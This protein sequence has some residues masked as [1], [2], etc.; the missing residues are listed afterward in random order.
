M[1]YNK[2]GRWIGHP[3]IYDSIHLKV[4]KY[5][6]VQQAR[7]ILFLGTKKSSLNKK[8]AIAGNSKLLMKKVGYS[9]GARFE[10]TWIIIKV[11]PDSFF[12]LLFFL[13]LQYYEAMTPWR[14]FYIYGY[15]YCCSPPVNSNPASLSLVFRSA[16]STF[17]ET[18]S[19]GNW[20]RANI[21]T[22]P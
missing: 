18:N 11:F 17:G 10:C 5:S 8:P 13:S 3:G 2:V 7:H 15:F 21:S 4:T 16:V 14:I 22:T 19:T 1:L 9:E 6:K 12:L 20:R